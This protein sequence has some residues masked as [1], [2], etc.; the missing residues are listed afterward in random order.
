MTPEEIKE[1]RKSLNLTQEQ[2]AGAF[3][4][5]KNTVA[6]WERG[7]REPDMPLVLEMAFNWLERMQPKKNHQRKILAGIY[8]AAE[9]QTS[10]KI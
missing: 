9:R 1:R 8:S 2:L 4:I 5:A 10:S 3:G 6:R 7:E